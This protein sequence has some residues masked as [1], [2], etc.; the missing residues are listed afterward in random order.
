M[1]SDDQFSNIYVIGAQSTGKTTLVDALEEFFL[2]SIEVPESPN[3]SKPVIIREVARTVLKTHKFT[4]NDI[5]NSTT[6]ALKL[7]TLILSAQLNAEEAAL[8]KRSSRAWY[9]SD[10]SG[11]DP[12]VYAT[13]F[14]GEDDAQDMLRGVEWMKLEERMKKG[15]VVLCEAGCSWLIDDGTR[16]M[17]KDLEEWLK[18][19]STFR[20][21]LETLDIEYVLLPKDVLD[22]RHRV[23]IVLKA[24]QEHVR[25]SE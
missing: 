10:R 19:D 5:T 21:L 11:L 25:R 4:R 24:H 12:V 3:L 16:L 14:A 18:V 1:V 23:E 8:E 20:A 22:T 6:R 7:Q 9:V 13:I 17:P 2:N 15:L